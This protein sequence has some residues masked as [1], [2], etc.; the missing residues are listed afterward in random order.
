[1]WIRTLAVLLLIWGVHD[2]VWAQ[3]VNITQLKVDTTPTV[4]EQDLVATLVTYHIW[5]G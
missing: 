5:L 4:N 1:M 2:S 3:K